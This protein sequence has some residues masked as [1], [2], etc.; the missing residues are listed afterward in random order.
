MASGVR[1][2]AGS[3]WALA[4]SGIAGPTGG[5]AGKPVG[6]VWFGLCDPTGAV[7]AFDRTLAGDREGVIARSVVLSLDTLRRALEGRSLPERRT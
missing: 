1:D 5:T 2:R 4:T 7:H 6:L 3:S